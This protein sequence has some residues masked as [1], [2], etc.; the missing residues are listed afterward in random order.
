MTEDHGIFSANLP[1]LKHQL[2]LATPVTLNYL[3][4]DFEDS[5]SSSAKRG[6][7]NVRSRIPV[8]LL[9]A[10]AQAQI[11]GHVGRAGHMARDRVTKEEDVNGRIPE[12]RTCKRREKGDFSFLSW[13]FGC[14]L[15]AEGEVLKENFY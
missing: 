4:S 7:Q 12:R 1:G 11:Q 10:A 14:K 2:L 8:E 13:C 9:L 15:W 6:H 3:F 5:V